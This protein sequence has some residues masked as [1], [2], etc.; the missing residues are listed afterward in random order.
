LIPP[1]AFIAGA[2]S[3]PMMGPAQGHSEFVAHFSAERTRWHEAKMVG[4]GWLSSTYETG[5]LSH[6]LEM[7]LVSIAPRL[8]DREHALVDMLG[9]ELGN[10]CEDCCWPPLRRASATGRVSPNKESCPAADPS[11]DA[12]VGGPTT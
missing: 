9:F 1:R 2:V 5:L 12:A 6:K 3:R 4:I 8:R 10:A 11:G 7:L